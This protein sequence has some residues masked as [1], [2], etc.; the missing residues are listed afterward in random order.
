MYENIIH[1][2][3]CLESNKLI[4]PFLAKK[5]GVGNYKC[6]QCN[7]LVFLR[8]GEL[9][10]PH[11]SHFLSFLKKNM[12]IVLFLSSLS[13]HLIFFLLFYFILFYFI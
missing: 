4:T 9:N 13:S 2:V 1:P 6:I 5:K 10:R 7:Q 12:N 8:K 3:L 11:F